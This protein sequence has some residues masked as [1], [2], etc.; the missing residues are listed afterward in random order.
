MR[1]LQYEIPVQ[2]L[3]DNRTYVI[4]YEINYI[5]HTHTHTHIVILKL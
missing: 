1:Y 3:F 5:P 4:F 2:S